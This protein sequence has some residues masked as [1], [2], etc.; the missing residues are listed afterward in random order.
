[1]TVESNWRKRWEFKLMLQCHCVCSS[2]IGTC[3]VDDGGK[4][5]AHKKTNENTFFLVKSP[6]NDI[7]YSCFGDIS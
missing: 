4:Q 6:P 3:I 2:D 5:A 7:L 1:M